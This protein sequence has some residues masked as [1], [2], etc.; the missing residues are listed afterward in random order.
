M[1]RLTKKAINRAI[2]KLN[3]ISFQ[4]VKK[5]KSMNS[6]IHNLLLHFKALHEI[7]Y[8]FK[9]QLKKLGKEQYLK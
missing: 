8:I 5:K 7:N 2:A 1:F 3:T 6:M 9:S 4:I